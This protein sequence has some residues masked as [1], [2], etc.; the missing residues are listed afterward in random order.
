MEQKL[1]D[2][3]F[4]FFDKEKGMGTLARAAFFCS[5]LCL[6][7][8]GLE[9]IELE[10]CNHEEERARLQR[11]EC[12]LEVFVGSQNKMVRKFGDF[13]SSQT[14]ILRLCHA[15]LRLPRKDRADEP[16]SR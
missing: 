2:I 16:S 10:S 14:E 4:F 13:S 8:V 9:D 7:S 5:G 6:M 15:I 1:K 12:L 11:L 3:P